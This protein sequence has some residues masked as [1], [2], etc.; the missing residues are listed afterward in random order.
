[1][2]HMLS[3]LSFLFLVAPPAAD[4]PA[5]QWVVVVAPAFRAAVQPLV[6]QRKAQGFLATLLLTTDVLT[7]DGIIPGLRL[8]VADA[9]RV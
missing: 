7:A 1:M 3:V 5:P 8:S 9:L 2:S 6:E 4:A